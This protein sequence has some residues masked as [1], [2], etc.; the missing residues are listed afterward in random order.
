MLKPARVEKLSH[1]YAVGNTPAVCYTQTLPPGQDAALLLLG[2]GDVRSVLFTTYS[3]SP[4][5]K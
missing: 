5:G 3:R 2:C 1:F 4:S